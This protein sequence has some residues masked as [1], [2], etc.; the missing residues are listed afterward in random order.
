MGHNHK[1]TSRK[2]KND[3]L[4]GNAPDRSQTVLL[5]VDVINDLDFPQNQELVSN[6][7]LL[8][9]RIAMLKRRCK[10][11]GI[12][13]IYVN[14][15]RGRWRSE[16]QEVVKHCLRHDSP[17]RAM[18]EQLLPD[19]DDYVVMK[20]KHSPFYATP[21]ELLLE[22]IGVKTVILAGFTTNA[23]VMIAASDLY[24]RDYR[25]FV[26]SDCVAALT[27][28]A[29]RNALILMRKNFG[30]TTTPSARLHLTRRVASPR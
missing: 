26:P 25:L 17:G 23:C 3:D 15:N 11:K 27:A 4:H 29:Q 6:S 13:T 1:S 8:G 28:G 16:F 7:V 2:N 24:I 14:D 19:K 20:P 10:Q 12:P 5:L 9:K 30:A 22:Y 18:V 21:L